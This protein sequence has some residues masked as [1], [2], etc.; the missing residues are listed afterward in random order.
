MEEIRDL[1]ARLSKLEA[2]FD[3]IIDLADDKVKEVEAKAIQAHS[4]M[5][6]KVET[7][8]KTVLRE[9]QLLEENALKVRID[10]LP[11]AWESIKDDF[12]ERINFLNET[13]NP[14]K[15]DY[16]MIECITSNMI[17]Y[18]T[19]R[20]RDKH[21]PSGH[22]ILEFGNREGK[23]KLLRQARLLKDTKS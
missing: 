3:S 19:S 16:D 13:L 23:L 17:E 18:I 9:Q 10:G 14:V 22:A 6:A 1:K 20:G 12:S 5:L 15:L 2:R 4:V 7:C 11:Q 8:V 21:I